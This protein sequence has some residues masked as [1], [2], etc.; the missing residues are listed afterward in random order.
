M[1]ILKNK[2]FVYLFTRYFTY[3]LQFVMSLIIAVRLGPYYLGIYGI[4]QLILNYINQI[5]FGIPHSLNVLLVHNKQNLKKQNS[6]ILNSIVLYSS[7]I[8]LNL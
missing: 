4:I 3:G 8:N 1:Q 5:N 7:Y 2:V 6:L